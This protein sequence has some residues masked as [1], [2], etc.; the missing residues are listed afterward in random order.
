MLPVGSIN[1]EINKD[2]MVNTVQSQQD[3]SGTN[4]KAVSEMN[5]ENEIYN[6]D[7]YLLTDRE[8]VNYMIC[9]KCS[10]LLA[11]KR[12]N[13][14]AFDIKQTFISYYVEEL[15]FC[16]NC[17]IAYITEENYISIQN[18]ISADKLYISPSNI[19]KTNKRKNKKYLYEPIA[20]FEFC[21]E[22]SLK[23]SNGVSPTINTLSDSSFLANDGYRTNLSD[24][25]RHQILQSAAKRYG[26]RRVADHLRFL[27]TTREGQN[28][29]M[30]KYENALRVWHADLNYLVE[31]E[32]QSTI[33]DDEQKDNII[34]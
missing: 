25:Q 20:G 32:H 8:C 17:S 2:I 4:H 18:R 16:P 9:P 26:K 27:I 22:K 13:V 10:S 7:Q 34:G 3:N 12:Y 30:I 1:F 15:L 5:Y 28:K 31:I 23:Q 14:P 21:Y 11:K 29:G 19:Q 6:I 24:D 33:S